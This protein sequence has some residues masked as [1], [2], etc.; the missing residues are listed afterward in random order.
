MNPDDVAERAIAAIENGQLYVLT[1]REMM[2]F[3]EER[4]RQIMNSR[5]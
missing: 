5:P 3:I 1:H 4:F 2:P